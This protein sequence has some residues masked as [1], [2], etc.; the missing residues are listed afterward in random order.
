MP[1]SGVRGDKLGP[2]T[3]RDERRAAYLKLTKDEL[4][5]RLLA[6]EDRVASLERRAVQLEQDSTELGWIKNP[7]GMGR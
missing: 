7:E 4:A 2:L 1:M 5:T 6:A 3:R